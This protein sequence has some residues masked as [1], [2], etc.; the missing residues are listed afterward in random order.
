M[1]VNSPKHSQDPKYQIGTSEN[2]RFLDLSRDNLIAF[3]RR[4]PAVDGSSSWLGDDGPP[5]ADRT[6]ATWSACRMTH[7]YSLA[8]LMGVDGA[9]ELVDDGVRG[10]RGALHDDENDGWDAELTPRRCPMPSTHASVHAVVACRAVA[11]G[12]GAASWRE[13]AGRLISHV[14]TWAEENDWRIP[15]HFDSAS[16]PLLKFNADKP[17]DQIKRLEAAA[18]VQRGQ[19][20]RPVQAVRR[21]AG[22]WH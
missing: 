16:K 21:Y 7:V 8:T 22:P 5:G 13:R 1:A 6:R 20:G 9:A 15:Q 2:K 14:L 19:A 12:T 3:G 17:D 18:R 4:F 10:L 11:A